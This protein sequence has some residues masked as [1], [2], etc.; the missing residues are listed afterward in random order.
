MTR[1][2][3]TAGSLLRGTG[4]RTA[5][6]AAT[7]AATFLL[8]PLLVSRLGERAYG[9]W[10]LA[11]VF[12]GYLGI[13]DVGLSSAA[14]RY[15]SQA[16]G[17][18][19]EEELDV[20]AR[21]GLVVF[22][23]A[24]AVVA[25]ATLATAAS[26]RLFIA[27]PDA[28]LFRQAVLVLGA[29]TAIGF[30]AKLHAGLL[31]ADI[32]YDVLAA[33]SIAKTT[34]LAA[35]IIMACSNGG[36]ILAVASVTAAV[37]LL[38]S[39]ATLVAARARF[40][41]LRLLPLR[42]DPAAG[43]ALLAYGRTTFVCQLGDVL[44]FRMAPLLIASFLGANLVTSYSVASRVVEGFCQLV[45]AAF[46]MM[47]PVFSRFEANGDYPG[48]R[49][50]LLRV[51]KLSTIVSCFVGLSVI[52]YARPFIARWMGPAFDADGAAA[53]AGVLAAGY[54]LALP[55]S[56][57]SQLLF[58]LSKHKIN[59]V[60]SVA[61]G[62]LNVALATLLLER[63]GLLGVAL[64]SAISMA[65]LKL[66]V[67]PVYVCRAIGLPLR[68]YL[69]DTIL[70]TSLKTSAPLAAYFLL[71]GRVVT[72]DYATLAA[73]LAVQTLLFLPAAYLLLLTGDER[74]ILSTAARELVPA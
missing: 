32:K 46:G 54:V 36:G 27:G 66:F 1:Q 50:A 34:L 63:Y 61:E 41:R 60:L 35:G 55:Q 72:A 12:V 62:L 2:T 15:L 40:P 67:Q 71:I 5:D 74:R 17:Q 42:Y 4:F 21:T 18:G 29:A 14:A 30:P 64:G 69:V 16:L 53:V 44:R 24:G 3:T 7:L 51:T 68:R 20:M 43:R 33:I 28:A 39:A 56:P 45:L 22:G 26:C 73:C 58:G 70:L 52:F 10:A 9:F 59:A 23:A 57:G 25:L 38:Q 8:T 6:L 13:L 65:A 37:T 47:L 19:D 11:L 49:S 31:A 48:L